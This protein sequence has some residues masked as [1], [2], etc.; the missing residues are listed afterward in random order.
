LASATRSQPR[1]QPQTASS[2]APPA[3]P[4][5]QSQPAPNGQSE[6]KQPVFTWS[7][8]TGSGRIEIAVWDKVVHYET[9][10]RVVYS[11]TCQ[12]SYRKQDESF[13]NT[14]VFW[15]TDLLVLAHGLEVVF[16]RIKE[17]HQGEPF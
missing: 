13:E 12:R 10:D 6:K 16:D 4:E 11:V 5:P 3:Q 15:H 17:M 1:Q 7:H 14:G 2:A 8:Q 9:G